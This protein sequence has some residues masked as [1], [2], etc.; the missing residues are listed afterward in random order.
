MTRNRSLILNLFLLSKRALSWVYY[1]FR[2]QFSSCSRQIKMKLR[3]TLTLLSRIFEHLEHQ[4]FKGWGKGGKQKWS[5][6]QQEYTWQVWTVYRT[7]WRKVMWTSFYRGSFKVVSY[8]IY[9]L[10]FAKK[11]ISLLQS[12]LLSWCWC[13]KSV[14][15]SISIFHQMCIN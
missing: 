14:D 15:K 5:S 1:I 12:I 8:Y 3:T 9:I 4:I 13:L 10:I 11:S 7:Y 2:G 6:K